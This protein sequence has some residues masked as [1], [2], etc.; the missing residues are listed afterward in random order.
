MTTTSV[1]L[2]VNTDNLPHANGSY[3]TQLWHIA[4]A[5][6]AEFGNTQACNVAEL[7]CREIVCRRLAV[8][9]PA[10]LTHTEG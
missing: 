1:T 6:P 9:P 5:S 2:H 7:V 4:Q 8:T 10:T 3:L